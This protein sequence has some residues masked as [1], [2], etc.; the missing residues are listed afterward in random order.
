MDTGTKTIDPLTLI[1]MD[2]IAARAG[3]KIDLVY[4]DAAHPEN[5]FKTA[6]YHPDALLWLHQDM[7]RIVCKVAQR[8]TQDHKWILILKDGLRPVEAQE[9]MMQTPIV[10]ANPQWTQGDNRLLSP[11]GG[12]AHPRGMAIDVSVEDI[13]GNPIDMGTP[14]D[15]MSE[16]SARAYQ[17]FSPI[18]LENRR[19]LEQAF[20]TAAQDLNLP[21]LPL[22]SEWW[23][24]RL[25]AEVYKPYAPLKDSDLPPWAQMTQKPALIDRFLGQRIEHFI[26]SF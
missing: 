1:P 18:I 24:F 11:S 16:K 23:D 10:K 13:N 19:I 14:F 25:G 4:A 12:G 21:L 15:G 17:G 6:L 22:P 26:D 20:L 5:I 3:F 2:M 7:A 8:L 9:K